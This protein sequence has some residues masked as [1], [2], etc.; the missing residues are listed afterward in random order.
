MAAAGCARRLA[1]ESIG[2]DSS[3][4]AAIAKAIGFSK[5]W[6]HSWEQHRFQPETRWAVLLVVHCRCGQSRTCQTG[7]SNLF[8]TDAITAQT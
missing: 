6:Q 2:F 3:F 7:S 4:L 8:A 5:F 1:L